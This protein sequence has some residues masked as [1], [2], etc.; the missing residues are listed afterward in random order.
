MSKRQDK[1]ETF[2]TQ[3]RIYVKKLADAKNTID[4]V[5][6]KNSNLQKN[7]EKLKQIDRKKIKELDELKIELK[8]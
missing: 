6:E 1:D 3:I 4:D 2:E 7:I 5:L 8:N